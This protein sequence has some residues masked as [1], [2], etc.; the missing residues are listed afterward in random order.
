M[1]R[2]III[3]NNTQET[4]FTIFT[5]QL[6]YNVQY[7]CRGNWLDR[8]IGTNGWYT[9]DASCRQCIVKLDQVVNANLDM[10]VATGKNGENS[11]PRRMP[12]KSRELA[13]SGAAW[14][15]KVETGLC[16]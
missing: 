9:W 2:V 6:F 16:K 4:G 3:N 14:L 15:G 7:L 1:I 11:L 12:R 10:R 5:C 8:L 13:E